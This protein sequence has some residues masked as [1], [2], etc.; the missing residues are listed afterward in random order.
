[1]DPI[2]NHTVW[3]LD[4]HHVDTIRYTVL[5]KMMNHFGKG[6]R[7]DSR[8]SAGIDSYVDTNVVSKFHKSSDVVVLVVVVMFHVVQK[9]NIVR[10]TID[11]SGVV[12]RIVT[13]IT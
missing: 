8:Q 10:P 1:M 9:T 6:K 5:N 12:N 13:T 7:F 2:E 11:F 3:P 4:S